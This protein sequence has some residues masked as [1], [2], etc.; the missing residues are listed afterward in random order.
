MNEYLSPFNIPGQMPKPPSKELLGGK[1]YY[2]AEMSKLGINVPYGVTI[3]TQAYVERADVD[4]NGLIDDVIGTLPDLPIL[5]SVRSGAAVSMP[6]MMDTIL[7]VGIFRHNLE[8]W[9]VILGENVAKDCYFRFLKMYGVTVAGR[10]PDDFPEQDGLTHIDELIVKRE[11]V[12]GDELPTTLHTTL[13]HC[14][15]AVH[16]SWMSPRAIAYRAEFGI[17]DH[18]G[19]A[20]T[21]QKMVFGNSGPDSATGVMFSR[22][23]MTGAALLTGEYLSN[24][25]GEDVV[26]GTSTPLTISWGEPWALELSNISKKLEKHNKDMQDIEFTVDCGELFLLQ[27]RT[28]KRTGTAAIKIAHDLCVEGI[29]SKQEAISRVTLADY[30][31]LMTPKIDPKY[32]VPPI[33][34]G[35]PASPGVVTGKVVTSSEKAVKSKG[36]VI[37]VTKETSPDDFPGMLAAVGILTETGGLTSHAAVVARGMNKCAIVGCG[38]LSELNDGDII[39][40]DGSTGEVW[41]G[42]VPVIGGTPSKEVGVISMWA[43]ELSGRLVGFDANISTNSP[44]ESEFKTLYSVLPDAG[45]IQLNVAGLTTTWYEGVT[46][47]LKSLK[48]KTKLGGV[49][50]LGSVPRTMNAK[51]AKFAKALGIDE[52]HPLLSGGKPVALRRHL[53]SLASSALPEACK[54]RWKIRLPED[55]PEEL[56]TLV[57][58]LKESGW[59]IVSDLDKKKIAALEVLGLSVSEYEV[60][61]KSAGKPVGSSAPSVGIDELLFEILK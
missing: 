48:A 6:G 39:S 45:N 7:N 58:A 14:V 29:I 34:M 11:M 19:T 15:K 59:V 61:M 32:S 40:L 36:N 57:D 23:P 55:L 21:V 25:Q 43:A 38:D 1:G 46:K 44:C 2:L 28:G 51:D 35:T 3:T 22:D 41:S 47:L 13:Y 17:P 20:V 52:G 54:G 33:A 26:A 12:F 24:A 31:A 42:T 8:Y 5:M 18:I 10:H 9:S 37:L 49:I 50:N 56:V 4:F 27:T 53:K 16:S 60:F 30:S